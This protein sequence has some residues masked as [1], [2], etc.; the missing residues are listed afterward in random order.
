VDADRFRSI[1]VFEESLVTVHPADR[2]GAETLLAF[3]DGCSYRAAAEAWLRDTGR[4]DTPV[5]DLG[6]LATMLG[7]VGAG[8]GFAVAPESAV[9]TYNALHTLKLTPLDRAHKRST[10]SLIWRLHATPTRTTEALKSVL[11]TV[12]DRDET[13]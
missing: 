5:R 12:K 3:P 4:G 10:M 13:V 9:R 7:C 11:K 1:E 2:S 8:L 6:S